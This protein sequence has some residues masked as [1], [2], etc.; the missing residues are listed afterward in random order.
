ME[1]VEQWFAFS[2]DQLNHIARMMYWVWVPGFLLSALVSLRYRTQAREAL[3]AH[4]KTGFTALFPR[5]VWYGLTASPGP[6]SS[7]ADALGLLRGGVRP[8]GALAALVATRN[9]PLYLVTI[10]TLLLGIEFAVG[11]VLGTVAMAACVYTGISAFTDAD[12]WTR[13]ASAN[14]VTPAALE[15]SRRGEEP[16][17]WRGLLFRHPGWARI[18]G[19]CWTEFKWFWPG[20]AGGVLVGGFVLAAGLKRWWIELAEVGGGG[21]IRDLL[22]A[23]VG[24][25]LGGLLSL[26]PGGNL[27]AGT[28]LFK[29]DT[30]GYPGLV[31]FV[32][33]SS[34]RL[35][36]LRAYA[37]TWRTAGAA[38]LGLV[39]YAAA[40]LG[41]LFATVVFALFGFRPGH[42][43][44]FR[45]LVDEIIKRV[46]FAMPSGPMR[47]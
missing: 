29:A 24:P 43:P 33:A 47:M 2:L 13:A 9:L 21:V 17:S 35:V 27:P 5:A 20:L 39:L 25:A 16:A 46:P 37:A 40:L 31:S 3:L 6:G 41:G 32:L 36:D 4:G 44:L 12:E 1:F 18:L 38:R 26:P 45:E 10:L 22:N 8:A 19:Y 28:A 42:I 23:A 30:L 34:V 14:G 11:H 15:P 7:L